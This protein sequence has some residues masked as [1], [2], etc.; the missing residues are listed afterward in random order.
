[1]THWSPNLPFA[2]M[3]ATLFTECSVIGAIMLL[4]PDLDECPD[5]A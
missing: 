5:K 1:M 2:V 4:R 3:C